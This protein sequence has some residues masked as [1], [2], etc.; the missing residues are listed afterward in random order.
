MPSGNA[1]VEVCLSGLVL[2]DFPS[3]LSV[4]TRSTQIIRHHHSLN[5]ELSLA[6][7]FSLGRRC[8]IDE[9]II[10]ISTEMKESQFESQF[11]SQLES[12][13]ESKAE[14]VHQDIDTTKELAESLAYVSVSDVEDLNHPKL[15][16]CSHQSGTF[17]GWISRHSLNSST[18]MKCVV[19]ICPDHWSFQQVQT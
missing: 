8:G 13:F 19:V 16:N 17:G 5:I 10:P 11:G 1:D 9:Y 2:K 12:Q 4:H 3:L 18:M 15:V 14:D 7:K 6:S